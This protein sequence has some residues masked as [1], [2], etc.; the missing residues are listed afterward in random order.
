MIYAF[1]K[2]I[3]ARGIYE[4]KAEMKELKRRYGAAVSMR[5]FE[6]N[7]FDKAS[8]WLGLDF[9][10]LENIKNKGS[11]LENKNDIEIIIDVLKNEGNRYG[12]VELKNGEKIELL[13]K[14]TY[15]IDK[16]NDANKYIEENFYTDKKFNLLKFEK[17]KHFISFISKSDIQYLK[18]GIMIKEYKN[19]KDILLNIRI[20]ESGNSIYFRYDSIL[21]INGA[22]NSYLTKQEIKQVEI[23]EHLKIIER[24]K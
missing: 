16:I 14:D 3:K 11:F 8:E 13:L 1:R 4:D 22:D 7:E 6:D 21:K 19:F 24:E 15:Y 20:P 18:D 9:E 10:E 2:P 17:N 12:K 5:A 23:L